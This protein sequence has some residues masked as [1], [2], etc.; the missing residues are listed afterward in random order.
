MGIEAGAGNTSDH[1][2]FGYWLRFAF[3]GVQIAGTCFGGDVRDPGSQ[4]IPKAR[5][6]QQPQGRRLQQV[7][8]PLQQARH[9]RDGC[10]HGALQL[11]GLFAQNEANLGA[12]LGQLCLERGVVLRQGA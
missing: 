2:G 4:A 8:S 9:A 1:E 10:S 12:G 11:I 3:C 5:Q 6:H 7:H